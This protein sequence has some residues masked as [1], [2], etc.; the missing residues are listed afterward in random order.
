[1]TRSASG[2]VDRAE[3]KASVVQAQFEDPWNKQRGDLE[4]KIAALQ[5][6]ESPAPDDTKELQDMRN[7]LR[8]LEKSRQKAL[9]TFEGTTLQD[10][11]IAARDA[12]ANYQMGAYWDEMFF[13][14]GAV[15]LAVGLLMV[16][17]VA[18]G[19]ERWVALSMIVII[20][21]SLFV[22]GFAWMPMGH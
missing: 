21:F 17:S 16:S 7:S 13:V 11:K 18:Q 6:K 8:E 12:A 14:A 19:A 2:G 5:D 22:I 9:R 15:I 10:A 3:A 4:R 20:T 1:M